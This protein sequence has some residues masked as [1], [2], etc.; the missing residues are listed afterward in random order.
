[1]VLWALAYGCVK[2]SDIYTMIVSKLNYKRSDVCET[3][4]GTVCRFV[5]RKSL[6]DDFPECWKG[7]M[8]RN[9]ERTHKE[10]AASINKSSFIWCKEIK[11]KI[12]RN[13]ILNAWIMVEQLSEGDIS[14]KDREIRTFP[15][16]AG[17]NYYEFFKSIL[18]K[19]KLKNKGGLLVYCDIFEFSDVISFIRREYL[20]E[21]TNEEIHTGEKFGYAL[22]FDKDMNFLEDKFFFSVSEYIRHKG[23]IPKEQEFKQTEK[24]IREQFRE[25]FDT[26]RDKGERE[27][28]S[29]KDSLQDE[30]FLMKRFNE[31]MKKCLA[32]FG[33]DIRT[34][35]YQILKNID[36]DAANLH[37]FYITDL[38][39]A[40]K[41]HTLNLEA[42]LSA[43]PAERIDLDAKIESPKF[44][45]LA[46]E[47]ILSPGNYP[48]GRFVNNTGYALSLMQQVAVNLAAGHD[49]QSIRSVN[50]PP[51]TGKS[52]LLKDIFGDLAVKQAIS[53]AE[54]RDKYIKGSD[55]TIYYKKASIGILPKEISDNNIVLASSN[56]GALQNI[57]N[58]LP[59]LKEVDGELLEELKEVDYFKD[60]S[61]NAFSIEEVKDGY[62]REHNEIRIDREK[63]EKFWG[64]FSLEGGKKENVRHLIRSISL[65]EKSMEYPD[66]YNPNPHVYEEFGRRLE[67]V[68]NLRKKALAFKKQ[69]K[70]YEC[71][72]EQLNNSQKKYLEERMEKKEAL[73]VLQDRLQQAQEQHERKIDRLKL[74]YQ[75]KET[76][77]NKSKEELERITNLINMTEL[78]KPG[79]FAPKAEKIAYREAYN[80]S[81]ELRNQ[82]MGNIADLNN[83]MMLLMKEQDDIKSRINIACDELSTRFYVFQTKQE[84]YEKWEQVKGTEMERLSFRI[85]NFRKIFSCSDDKATIN[86]LKFDKSYDDLQLSNP[87]YGRDYRIA[88]SRLFISAL[89]VRKQFLYENRKNIKAALNIW[90]NQN[91]HVENPRLIQAA[92]NWIN[93]VVPVISTTFASFNRMCKLLDKNTIGHL[94][95]DEAGQAVPQASVGAIFRSKNVM[96]VGDPSQIKPVL[97]LDSKVL[98]LLCKHFDV[99]D[100]YLS[101]E[102]STQTL[103]DAISR[104]GFYKSTEKEEDSWVG[105]PLWVHRRCRYPMFNISNE[106]SY[107]GFMVQANKGGF[108]KAYWY[109]VGGKADNKYVKEQGEVLKNIISEMIKDNPK[110]TDV[111]EKDTIY[112]ISPFRNV[113]YRLAQELKTIAFTRYDKNGKPTNV[114]TIHTFQGKEAPIVF[115]VLGADGNSKGA[116]NWAVGEANMM[117]VAATRAKEEFYVIGSRNL[118]L[119]IDSEV[120]NT[121]YRIINT[122][123]KEHPEFVPLIKE[124][125]NKMVVVSE[126]SDTQKADVRSEIDS[127]NIP[128]DAIEISHK[129]MPENI[130]KEKGT[131]KVQYFSAEEAPELD[132]KDRQDYRTC[133]ECGGK[134]VL[135][136]GKYGPFYGCSTFPKCRYTEKV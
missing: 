108:G 37:S 72:L 88:Q 36:S 133:P 34:C 126:P 62:G 42:Y 77:Y 114:G 99:D 60:I 131:N 85:E 95:I 87:W 30:E 65:V 3:S 102:A 100:R 132:F 44:N 4:G 33:T 112:V 13:D 76:D 116:A 90:N 94:F 70:E 12:D 64:L 110:I 124:S 96:V 24:G 11:M 54:L 122:Y 40:K 79:W 103:I 75:D 82:L 35:R 119:N 23:R 109:D 47:S 46:F 115:M 43:K 59:L 56:N 128:E 92:W 51:G 134:L 105:I 29:S 129:E 10:M 118:Y 66:Y 101:N 127:G 50:G 93:F 16:E 125:A 120:A 98:S 19:N 80:K 83:K 81:L 9:F 58:E 106:I 107:N 8:K 31:A 71:D 52:T 5:Y 123:N 67:I 89:K 97:T 53:I 49:N 21:E 48:L 63:E 7:V 38:E 6:K 130:E 136:N 28:S 2:N 25:Y 26:D 41:L 22:Y 135:H 18:C 73:K 86:S 104:Y 61:N 68:Y 17:K 27:S 20:L 14:T 32:K 74:E 84:E 45:P 117:N 1:M 121:T 39:K 57:V 113:A 15:E 78:K 111:R 69:V 91:E 55:E